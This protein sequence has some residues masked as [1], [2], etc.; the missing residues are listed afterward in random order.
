VGANRETCPLAGKK[1]LPLITL[2][3]LIFTDLK[4][5]CCN[6]EDWPTA[7]AANVAL[8]VKNRGPQQQNIAPSS[9]LCGSPGRK[10]YR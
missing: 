1:S 7:R 5:L 3:A 9:G 10:A 4:K 2:I 6:K 8:S